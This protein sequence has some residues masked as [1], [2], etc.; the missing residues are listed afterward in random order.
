MILFLDDSGDVVRPTY[1]RLITEIGW[2]GSSMPREPRC[3]TLYS[4]APLF[5]SSLIY[6]RD[7]PVREPGETDDR[8]T[9]P[10][11]NHRSIWGV[12][13][14]MR[15]RYLLITYDTHYVFQSR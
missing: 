8:R 5:S 11:T 9:P 13:I 12:E 7:C 10:G 2:L 15:D 6:P 14:G 1:R 3:G 4:L